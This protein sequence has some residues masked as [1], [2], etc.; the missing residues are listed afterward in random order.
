MKI[1]PDE[2]FC[3]EFFQIRSL[4]KLPGFFESDF[5][6]RILPQLSCTEPAVFHAVIALAS[7]QRSQEF[8]GC[9]RISPEDPFVDYDYETEKWERFALQQYNKA[10]ASV[11]MKT[12]RLVC[13]EV[14]HD[15]T[16]RKALLGQQASLT[17]RNGHRS[18]E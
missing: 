7:T 4:V 10:I 1:E 12:S 5:W 6:D 11:C 17:R 16:D 18:E 9:M 14:R 8:T 13:S 3:L 2:L 15:L